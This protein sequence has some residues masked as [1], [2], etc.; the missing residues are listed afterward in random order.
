MSIQTIGFIKTTFVG[1]DATGGPVN[2]SV[3]GLKAG[4]IVI[5]LYPIANTAGPFTSG[6]LSNSPP[7]SSNQPIQADDQFTQSV[8]ADTSPVTF[9]IVVARLG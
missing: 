8:G 3:P 9:E 5:A 7:F 4:D 2:I 6:D 1:V